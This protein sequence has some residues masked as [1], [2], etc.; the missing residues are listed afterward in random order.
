M[1]RN[2]DAQYLAALQTYYRRHRALGKTVPQVVAIQA[3]EKYGTLCFYYRGG[4]EYIA[5]V[6]VAFEELTGTRCE[7]CGARGRRYGGGWIRTLGEHRAETPD[8]L[9]TRS[10]HDETQARQVARR[11]H[12]PGRLCTSHM[13]HDARG[14]S[15]A[16]AA[17]RLAG[18][19]D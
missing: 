14:Q 3:K 7:V 18:D 2:V 5:H 12:R 19:T 15:P 10:C 17:R 1:P 16:A 6:V 8:H 11:Q 13:A 4:N 9:M